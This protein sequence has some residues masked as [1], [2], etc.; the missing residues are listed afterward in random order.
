[1]V[2]KPRDAEPVGEALSP[3][4]SSRA[5]SKEAPETAAS[6]SLPS[7]ANYPERS[8]QINASHSHPDQSLSNPSSPK[9]KDS[10]KRTKKEM[11]EMVKKTK[12]RMAAR[13]AESEDD[14]SDEDARR[15]PRLPKRKVRLRPPPPMK[16]EAWHGPWLALP[17]L[18]QVDVRSKRC[19]RE[20]LG[21]RE[22]K[23]VKERLR[24]MNM[25]RGMEWGVLAAAAEKAEKHRAVVN[26]LPSIF[27]SYSRNSRGSHG[28]EDDYEDDY[29]DH[30]E[31]LD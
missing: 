10:P 14:E 16:K 1:M 9:K 20:L 29:D 18:C 11:Q 7:D 25:E 21:G 2:H 24:F 5:G 19:E 15:R 13:K 8:S 4:P 27:G 26:K 23:V 6:P 28:Y 31:F 30:E 3:I 22:D 17:K 12:K